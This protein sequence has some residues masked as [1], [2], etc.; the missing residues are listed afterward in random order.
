MKCTVP[1]PT[2]TA[3]RRNG[4][5][6]AT[7]ITLHGVATLALLIPWS[8]PEPQMVPP[9]IIEL[10]P[11]PVVP[12]TE[13]PSPMATPAAPPPEAAPALEAAPARAAPRPT[14]RAQAARITPSAETAPGDEAPSSPTPSSQEAEG[15]GAAGS[16]GGN[17]GSSAPSYNLGSAHTPA[18]DYPWSARRRGIEGRVVIRLEV[19]ADGC[20]TQVELVHSSGDAALDRAALTTLWH[21]RLLPAMA[22]GVPVAGRVTVPIVFKLT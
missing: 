1:R 14:Q 3:T 20:P 9:I 6:A 22:D 15:G 5:A 18:P 21:W 4:L 19:A 13:A 2:S 11:L 7:S 10:V 12:K 8:M 16:P 17:S